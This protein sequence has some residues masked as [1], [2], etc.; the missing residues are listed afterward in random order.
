VRADEASVAEAVEACIVRVEAH[1]VL[2]SMLTHQQL[3]AEVRARDT[4][5]TARLTVLVP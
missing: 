1:V 2:P 3:M 5:E 4:D